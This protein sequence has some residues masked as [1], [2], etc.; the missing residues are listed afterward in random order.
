MV[1]VNVS[2]HFLIL[3][4]LKPWRMKVHISGCT[5][6]QRNQAQKIFQTPLIKFLDS[7]FFLIAIFSVNELKILL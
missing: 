5:C 7:G 3:F 2:V 4:R 6:Q 1:V